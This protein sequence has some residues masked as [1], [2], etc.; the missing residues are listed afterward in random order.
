[1]R[2][3]DRFY[4]YDPANDMW[5]ALPPLSSP[6]GSPALAAVNGK[7]HAISGRTANDVGALPV[8]EVYDPATN[9][10]TPASP[11]PVGRDHVGIGVLDGKIH[12]YVGRRTDAIISKVSL[13][14]VYDPAADRW[15]AMPSTAGRRCSRRSAARRGGPSS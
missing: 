9:R 8:H 15:T 3:T 6:R 2:S 5:R 1:M 14:H 13:H 11:I 10:W 7:I 4:V 12:I